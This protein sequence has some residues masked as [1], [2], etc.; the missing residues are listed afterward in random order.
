MRKRHIARTA[1]KTA[2]I[3]KTGRRL[4]D[5]RHLVHRLGR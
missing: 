4:F 1:I 5:R 2:I 3:A